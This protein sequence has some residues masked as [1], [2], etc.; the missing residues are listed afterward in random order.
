MD[1]DFWIER[2]ERNQIGFHQ[3]EINAYL[4]EFWKEMRVPGDGR[5]FVPLCGKSLDMIWLRAQGHEVLGVEISPVAVRDFFSENGLRYSRRPSGELERYES[6]GLT[7][8][9]GDFFS[10]TA[11]DLKG[12]S[13]AYD[14]ASLVAFPQEMRPAYAAHLGAVL[15]AGCPVLL[16]TLEYPLEEM[17]GPPFPVPE[18]EVQDLFGSG[19]AVRRIHEA[20]VLAEYPRF[21]ERGL[22]RL[23]ERIFSLSPS[24]V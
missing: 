7:V 5:V 6:D 13:S 17:Q 22:S 16:V 8:L 21:R 11:D 14:R 18:D 20:D 19:Y 24:R 15:P 4:R 3:D 9:C 2:W 10:L 1:K 23:T 12:C